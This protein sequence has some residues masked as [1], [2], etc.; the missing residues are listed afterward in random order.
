MISSAI[1][2]IYVGC[3][4]EEEGRG[5][6]SDNELNQLSIFFLSHFDVQLKKKLQTMHS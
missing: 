3:S 4:E 2:I 6:S 5:H 1:F